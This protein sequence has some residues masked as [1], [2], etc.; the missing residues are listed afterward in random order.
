M[1]DHPLQTAIAESA[2]AREKEVVEAIIDAQIRI[3]SA[4]YEKAIAYTNL[5]VLAGYASF[6]GLWQLTKADITKS[7]SMWAALCI[8]LSALVFVI[9]EVTKMYVSSR[10][11][12]GL[13]KAISNPTIVNSAALLLAEIDKV[14]KSERRV[15]VVFGY[16]WHF[17]LGFTILTG[18]AG[19]GILA[20]AF[21]SALCQS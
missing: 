14:G 12:L 21:I 11:L 13:N 5:I 20:Y 19:A 7:Q 17:T 15:T 1:A 10:T 4:A 3:L 8:L 6:F 2:A 18:L 9:F 16:W